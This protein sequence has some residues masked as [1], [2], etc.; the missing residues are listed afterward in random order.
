MK[1]KSVADIE[2]PWV[3]PD[4]KSGLIDRCKA[5][6]KVPID[7]LSDLMV[8]TY[9]NQRIAA[10]QLVEEAQRRIARQMPDETE[11]YDGQLAEA[12]E[13]YSA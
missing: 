6:W 8:A 2:G 9:L 12:V 5:H 10:A 13:S 1:C 7:Q 3:D 11:L 4:F